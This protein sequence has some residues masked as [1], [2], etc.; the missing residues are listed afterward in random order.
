MIGT[1]GNKGESV[2]SDCYVSINI[3]KGT[4]IEIDL[5]SKVGALYGNTIRKL[6]TDILNFFEIR[7]AKIYIEDKGA[8]DFVIAAR[9]ESA[10]LEVVTSSKEYLLPSLPEHRFATRKDA[11]RRS[12]LYIPGNAPKLMINA[13]IHAADAVILDLEDS[14][15]PDKKN[16]A[17]LLVRN[18]LRSV[19]FYGAERMVRINQIPEGLNDLKF[20]VPHEVNVI[21]LPKCESAEQVILVEEEIHRLVKN[22]EHQIH[23]MPIIESALGVVNAYDIA[24]ASAYVAALAIGLEDYTADLGV[25][26]SEAGWESF[27]ARSAVVNA[28]AA[29]GIQAID[30]VYSDV[31]NTDGLRNNV[32]ASK[33]MGFVG[34]GCIHPRQVEFINAGFNPDGAEIEKAKA[35]VQAFEE[36][37]NKGLAI[38]AIGSKMIDLPVVKRAQH[39]LDAAI[40]GGLLKKNWREAEDE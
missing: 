21:L 5:R 18:A 3:T 17:R 16:E 37:R 29:S 14:V 25:A 2:R 20:V 13:G 39:T 36:A 31:A 40:I 24:T 23:L 32:A 10:I 26:R 28:A 7:H 1:A 8:L 27:Y 35:I 22:S 12:R 30:S 4:G 6:C 33:A 34:M 9:L 15:A 11:P 38:I 19:N